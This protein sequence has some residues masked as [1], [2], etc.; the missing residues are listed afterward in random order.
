MTA[1]KG[2]ANPCFDHRSFIQL[3]T[4][5]KPDPI[6]AAGST[7]TATLENHTSQDL[8]D[9]SATIAVSASATTM[10]ALGPGGGAT[11]NHRWGQVPGGK[12][13]QLPVPVLLSNPPP[14]L[15]RDHVGATVTWILSA[16]Q[17]QNG[18]P[19]K[20]YTRCCR[21]ALTIP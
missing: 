5:N 4:E 19:S 1:C 8:F 12:S 9:A 3:V 2:P 15:V 17:P 6:Q 10:I 14:A 11:H 16:S 18:H 13:S 20:T 7:H 21:C